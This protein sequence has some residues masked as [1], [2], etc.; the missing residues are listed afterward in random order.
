MDR[1]AEAYPNLNKLPLI[2]PLWLPA[3]IEHITWPSTVATDL[4]KWWS[5]QR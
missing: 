1:T 2:D 5:A 4:Q 3:D